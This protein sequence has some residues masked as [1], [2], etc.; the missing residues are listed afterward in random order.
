MHAEGVIP[1]TD[2]QWCL[3]NNKLDVWYKQ[4]SVGGMTKRQDS[5]MTVLAINF[6]TDLSLLCL[7]GV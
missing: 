2:R 5:L 1:C 4:A 3:N 6:V 7:N